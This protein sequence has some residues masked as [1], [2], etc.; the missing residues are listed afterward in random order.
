MNLLKWSFVYTRDSKPVAAFVDRCLAEAYAAGQ[1][2]LGEQI[3][4]RTILIG[5][6]AKPLQLLRDMVTND[7]SR[8]GD[9]RLFRAIAEGREFLG[10]PRRAEGDEREQARPTV[11]C[12]CGSTRFAEA[13]RVANLRETIA[14][15]IVLSIGCDTKS[16][17]DLMALGELT[18]AA[19][20][21]LDELHKR[22]ID[23]ADEILVLNVGGYIGT[24]TR[25]E[26]EY[27]E[28][29]HKPIRWLETPAGG[30][31]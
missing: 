14:G 8:R 15:R 30:A 3:V 1:P 31:A 22:K 29:H 11:V 12:L 10:L 5:G 18:P 9:L 27:A 20:A 23:L 6:L 26:I 28:L 7:S 4:N 24:S 25:S 19:K 16:D 13:F 21:K 2:E 17:A